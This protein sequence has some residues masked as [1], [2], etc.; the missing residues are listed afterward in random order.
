[1]WNPIKN[2]SN[3]V[4]KQYIK[5]RTVKMRIKI[6]QIQFKINIFNSKQVH[7]DLK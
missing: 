1:M 5:L 3:Q 7:I 6:N 4:N 2:K